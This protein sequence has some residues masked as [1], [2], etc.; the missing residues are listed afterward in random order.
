MS[1][2][3]HAKLALFAVGLAGGCL[4]GYYASGYHKQKKEAKK[5]LEQLAA[6]LDPKPHATTLK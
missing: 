1:L 2:S 3:I 6:Q 5:L 4:G